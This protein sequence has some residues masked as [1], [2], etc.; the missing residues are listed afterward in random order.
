MLTNQLFKDI[1]IV[2][3]THN[4]ENVI[5]SFLETLDRRFNLCII[6][7]ASKDKT[8]LILKKAKRTRI[9]FYVCLVHKIIAFSG[10]TLFSPLPN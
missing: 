5:K 9:N 10:H 7:N 8:R 4:S 6:D 2:T 1:T 3:V